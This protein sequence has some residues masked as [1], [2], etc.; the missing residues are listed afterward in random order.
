MHL[1]HSQAKFLHLARQSLA[2]AIAKL[3]LPVSWY[4]VHLNQQQEYPPVVSQMS[5][6]ASELEPD[7]RLVPTIP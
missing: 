4:L 2:E 1:T 7:H 5:A 3:P 6:L